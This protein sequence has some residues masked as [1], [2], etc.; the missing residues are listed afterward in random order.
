MS[1]DSSNTPDPSDPTIPVR[2]GDTPSQAT[3]L[4][5][6]TLLIERYRIVS[7]LGRG[8]MGQ[9]Y[10][11][12]DLT[13]GHSVALKF[14]PDALAADEVRLARLREEVRQARLVSHRNVCRVHD[15]AT[16][17]GDGDRPPRVFIAMEYVDGEDLAS[18]LRR[19]GRLP[20]D[21]GLDVARQLCSALAAV[22]AEGIIHRDLKPENVM[23]DGRGRVRLMD[24][25][26]A[27]AVGAARDVRSGT[28]AYM[29]PEQHAGKEATERSDIYALGLVIHEVLTGRHPGDTPASRSGTRGSGTRSATD[30]EP[31]DSATDGII[32]RCLAEDP[33]ARPQS[34]LAVAFALPGGDP[35][36]AAIAAGETPS[37]ELIAAAGNTGGTHP[38]L[39]LLLVV[40]AALAT[41]GSLFLNRWI[42]IINIVPLPRAT[43]VLK[44]QAREAMADLGYPDAPFDSFAGWT[45]NNAALRTLREKHSVDELLD[46]LETRRTRAIMF[47]YR[48]SPQRLTPLNNFG[49]IGV[50]DPPLLT[51]GMA[52]Y[53]TDA[54][55]RLQTFRAVPPSAAPVGEFESPDWARPFALAGLNIADFE[56]APPALNP[57]AAV[58]EHRAWT[59]E[60]PD[61]PGTRVTVHGGAYAGRVSEFSVLTD[62]DLEMARAAT[63]PEDSRNPIFIW[64]QIVM[65]VGTVIAG[66]ALSWRNIRLR[67]SDHASATRIAL[68]LALVS[69]VGFILLSSRIP[70]FTGLIF[71]N[72]PH[73]AATL[74]GGAIFWIFYV[75]LEPFARKVWPSILIGWARLLSGRVR[76]PMV[77]RD[78]LIALCAGSLYSLLMDLSILAPMF[79]GEPSNVIPLFSSGDGYLVGPKPVTGRLALNILNA[80]IGGAAQ[81]LF[82]V[83]LRLILRRAI[84]AAGVYSLIV[85]ALNWGQS[86]ATMSALPTLAVLSAMVVFVMLRYGLLPQILAIYT[87][88]VIN[89]T[90]VPVTM[91]TWFA[92]PALIPMGLL[93][94]AAIYGF[95]T[96]TRGR[97]LLPDLDA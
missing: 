41:A 39:A 68:V 93:T 9:V 23:L 69:G 12:D 21:K 58:T 60:L 81:L 91:D 4:P 16:D 75:A 2:G 43:A 85:L 67:R 51:P 61:E 76:D 7:Y 95:F 46:V 54:R 33:A 87:S 5:A 25:G 88:T 79:T 64:L 78:I 62:P 3:T 44:D 57:K 90:P 50:G 30:H 94:A 10:R 31:L 40:I 32:K 70:S 55:G 22:H 38:G 47:W 59:G 82:L 83:L 72:A 37:P 29:S 97:K 42:E 1:P 24:F 96:A 53:I 74:L 26:I 45:I 17:P 27:A 84:L 36:A 63:P 18:L 34:A 86:G 52:F 11:A 65:V 71:G 35:L 48:E 73:L 66:C 8:G 6:G 56:P 13:L 14:L 92:A 49:F 77:G 19:I 89:S 28:P 80:V 15:I 20:L